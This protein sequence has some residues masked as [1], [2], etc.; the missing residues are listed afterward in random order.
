MVIYNIGLLHH[1]DGEQEKA[2]MYLQKAH[3]IDPD[4]FEVEL[5]LGQMFF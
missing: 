1:I 2:L 3:G 5:L 4:V